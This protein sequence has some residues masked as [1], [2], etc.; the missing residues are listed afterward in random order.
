MD[1]GVNI[2]MVRPTLEGVPGPDLPKGYSLRY[3]RPG[4]EEAWTRIWLAADVF[5]QATPETFARAYGDRA[6]AL[7]ERQLFLCDD[8]QTAV[9]TATAWFP[10]SNVDAEA[11]LV[12]WV[13]IVPELQGRGLARP[14]LSATLL[15]MR[16][17]GYG[18]AA[19]ITQSGRVPAVG[20]YL[21]FG[22]LPRVRCE[23]ERAAWLGLREKL[24]GAALAQLDL[25]E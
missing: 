25:D 7:G 24:P 6:E 13:A 23:A 12:H 4:D 9:G 18:R 15:R 3:Y 11:G 2:M 22:F 19:L 10:D 16:E 8:A 1:R 5:G 20:L 21:A 17:L 14:L